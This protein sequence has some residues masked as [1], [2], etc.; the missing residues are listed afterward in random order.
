MPA[1][2]APPCPRCHE[3]SYVALLS[4]VEM[5]GDAAQTWLCRS[6]VSMF[7]DV[8][9]WQRRTRQRRMSDL[10]HLGLALAAVVGASA[11]IARRMW[12]SLEM[13]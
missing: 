7:G 12:G 2:A 13:P 9:Q 5:R 4:T 1:M 11:L 10:L 8:D 6:C 3:A